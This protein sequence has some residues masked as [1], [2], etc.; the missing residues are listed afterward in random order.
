MKKVLLFLSLMPIINC[1]EKSNT[2]PAQTPTKQEQK[3]IPLGPLSQL[4]KQAQG[5]NKEKCEHC[6]SKCGVLTLAF[7]Q[8][9][10][11]SC[12]AGIQS[13]FNEFFAKRENT[14]KDTKSE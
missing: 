3:A 1:S 10:G 12:G 6:V 7:I 14:Q 11:R 13:F 4:K 5:C 9:C 8:R 2:T